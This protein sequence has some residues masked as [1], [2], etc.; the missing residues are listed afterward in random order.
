MITALTLAPGV[1]PR[2]VIA[3]WTPAITVVSAVQASLAVKHASSKDSFAQS[4][5]ILV[6]SDGRRILLV[7][8]G[9]N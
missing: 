7:H 2:V 1:H 5:A 6:P 3:T 4:I 8:V 9:R